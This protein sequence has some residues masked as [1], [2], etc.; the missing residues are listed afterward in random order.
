[1]IYTESELNQF[2]IL[3]GKYCLGVSTHYE[4]KKSKL[5]EN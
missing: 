3:G 5:I 4:T 1:M 2:L